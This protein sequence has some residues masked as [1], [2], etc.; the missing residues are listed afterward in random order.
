VLHRHLNILKMPSAFIIVYITQRL[1]INFIFLEH[2][3]WIEKNNLLS[4]KGM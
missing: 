3:H 4:I 1:K 2:L